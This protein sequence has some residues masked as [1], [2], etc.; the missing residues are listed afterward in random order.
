MASDG[1]VMMI[2]KEAS[3]KVLVGRNTEPKWM[4]ILLP[5]VQETIKDL[6]AT[7]LRF[8]TW[9]HL[10][11]RSGESPVNGVKVRIVGVTLH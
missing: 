8:D 2:M 3:A 1:S 5:E 7:N 4:V 6:I 10:L 9:V 11:V